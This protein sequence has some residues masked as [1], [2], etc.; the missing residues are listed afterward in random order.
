M[1]QIIKKF[2]AFHGTEILI[3]VVTDVQQWTI[4][5]I[6]HTFH[7]CLFAVIEY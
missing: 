3:T 6:V 5:S 7:L 1:F 2:P 4:L